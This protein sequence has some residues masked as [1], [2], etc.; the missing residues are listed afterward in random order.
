MYNFAGTTLLGRDWG[1]L[2]LTF[3]AIDLCLMAALV[4]LRRTTPF[5]KLYVWLATFMFVPL[6]GLAA[7]IMV[8]KPLFLG[9]RTP[10]HRGEGMEE[11]QKDSVRPELKLVAPFARA[12]S[13]AGAMRYTSDSTAE[14]IGSGEEYFRRLFEDMGNARESF[15]MECYLIRNDDTSR[16]FEEAVCAMAGAG[17]RV[18]LI[19]D[20]YGYDAKNLR[21][22]R[23]MRRAGCEVAIFHNMTKCLFNPKKNYRNH[24]KTVVIDGRIAY[25][26]GYNIGNEYRVPGPLGTWR[27][28]AVRIVG[29]QAREMQRMFAED[30]HYVTGEDI[31]RD[32]ALFPESA[33]QE[34]PVPMQIVP[35]NPIEYERN[36]IL[37][38]FLILNDSAR[39]RIWIETPYFVPV[40]EVFDDLRMKAAQGVD[41]RVIMPDRSDHPC[42]YWANRRYAYK[43]A[44]V[45]AKIYEYRG[46]FIHTKMIIADDKC[47]S[48][49]S[50]NYDE[51]STRLN[52]E[53]NVMM[54]SEE[55][56]ARLAEEFEKDQGN[57][58]P[59][60]TRVY[61]ER[62]LWE[63]FKTFVSMLYSTQLR[64]R[65]LL[66]QC[67]RRLRAHGDRHRCD[68]GEKVR[69]YGPRPR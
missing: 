23:R 52:W 49:G 58:T 5:R 17:V 48:L 8:G 25:Q 40:R 21:P 1:A 36:P 67:R 38:Q 62:T 64:P 26:G 15:S 66:Y 22:V 12:L 37:A 29:N 65:R 9:R 10:Y 11:I 69:G 2:E 32:P 6:I 31:S 27:D 13:T 35:G 18:R 28:G 59:F 19:F 3:L 42:V 51:R 20:D 24:R 4:A 54:Y 45:G 68:Q 60:D 7:Y 41:V 30:W 57:S 39:E 61:S 33:P 47:C 16:R 50:A 44:A 55:M 34:R 14:Y 43:L 63:R 46:G 53:C 56:C